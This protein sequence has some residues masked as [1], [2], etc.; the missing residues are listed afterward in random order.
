MHYCRIKF[1]SPK[2]NTYLMYIFSTNFFF[3]HNLALCSPSPARKGCHSNKVGRN[4]SQHCNIS[5]VLSAYDRF[6]LSNLKHAA[7]SSSKSASVLWSTAAAAGLPPHTA[8]RG[9]ERTLKGNSARREEESNRAILFAL[10]SKHA[11]RFMMRVKSRRLIE[12]WDKQS[13][14]NGTEEIVPGSSDGPPPF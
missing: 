5:K 8:Q 11:H 14:W 1:D 7:L 3:F 4:L 10:W 13:P 2:F 9:R 12:K 6:S